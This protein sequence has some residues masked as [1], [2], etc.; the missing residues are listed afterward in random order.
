VALSRE[1]PRPFPDWVYR[2]LRAIAHVINRSY[3]RVTVQGPPVP[4]SGAVVLAPVHRS[5]I[6]FFVVSEVTRRKLFYM[7]KEE[8]WS[9]HLLGRFLDSTGAIPVHREGA[10]RQSVARSQAVL[11]QGQV[12]VLFPEGTRRSG[13]SVVDLHEGAAFLATRTGAPIVPVGI[14]GT[15]ESQPLGTKLPRPV[16]V[17]IVL[18]EPLMPPA[19]TEGG[20]TPRRVI[21][22]LNE[23]LRSELQRVYDQARSSL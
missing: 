14:A 12:L 8:M 21:R 16:K 23:Q 7:T 15:S 13:D 19:R 9:S 5:F 1:L 17:R 4:A 3:W 6:D 10:D 18:G 22:E 2:S 20:R 11:D